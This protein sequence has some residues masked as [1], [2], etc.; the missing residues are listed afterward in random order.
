MTRINAWIA[1]L[2]VC[3]GTAVAQH[4]RDWSKI[5]VKA[6]KVA[7]NVYMLTGMGGNIGVSVG[8]DGIVVV[9]T[10]FA[11][12]APKIQAALKGITDKPVRFILNTHWHFDHTG[13]NSEFSRQGT[14]VAHEN[15][16][17]RLQSGG[18]TRFGSVPPQP[19]AMLPVITFN[20]QLV[21][22]LNDEEIRAIHFPHSHTD[23]DIAIAFKGSG[24]LHMGDLFFN[25]IF[26]Y[27]DAGNGGSVKGLIAT[28]ERVLAMDPGPAPGEAR[29]IPGHGPLATR[30]DLVAY[31]E[32]LRGTSAAVEAAIKK[33]RTLDQMKQ[34]KVLA[35]WEEKW[36][37]GFLK[38]DDFIEV[39]Y[40]A[41]ARKPAAYRNHGHAGEKAGGK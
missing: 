13:G 19:P 9:D 37:K 7:G 29:I 31:L 16:R 34:E 30:A 10:Q 8:E 38:T 20:D 27:I 2:L 18:Q 25:G 4:E 36:G 17:A 21:V 12:L 26:P 5:E 28:I 39:L 35:A 3:A 40:N 24:V 32:M 23:G 6:Q 15:V 1:I 11:P 22:H 14:V 33:G 41:L